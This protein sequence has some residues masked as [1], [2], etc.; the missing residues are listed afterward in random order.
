[1]EANYTNGINITEE[2]GAVNIGC[3]IKKRAWSSIY[4]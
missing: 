2:I 4:S 1:M 3:K